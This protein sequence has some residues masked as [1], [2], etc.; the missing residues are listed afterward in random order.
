MD[1]TKNYEVENNSCVLYEVPCNYIFNI[2][3]TGEE[4]GGFFDERESNSIW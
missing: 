2:F 1:N 3:I 4:D